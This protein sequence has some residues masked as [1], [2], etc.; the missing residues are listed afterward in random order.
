M[1]TTENIILEFVIKRAFRTGSVMRTD[2]MRVFEMKPQ[3]AT[4]TLARILSSQ[5]KLIE[6]RGKAIFPKPGAKVPAFAGEKA[7]LMELDAGENDPQRTGIFPEELPVHYISWTN[8]APPSP[9]ILFTIIGAIRQDALLRIVY[10]GMKKG[11]VPKE[12]RIIPL[13]LDRINDQWRLVAQDIQTTF[14]KETRRKKN[15]APLRTFVLSR[16]LKAEWDR[17]RMPK[18]IPRLGHWDD[19]EE[20]RVTVNTSCNEHQKEAVEREIGIERG[21]VRVPSRAR[22]EFERRFM[23]TPPSPGALWPPITKEP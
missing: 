20:L 4:N 3:T 19:I 18:G 9:G 21:V 15:E 13:A 10:I 1:K 22:F 6:R 7:L 23:N 11:E 14:S 2:L 16:I 17:G 5:G 12:R 8:S